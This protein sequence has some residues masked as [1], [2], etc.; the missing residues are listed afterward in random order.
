M[1]MA[2]KICAEYV[3]DENAKFEMI[4]QTY[5]KR[6]KEIK[7]LTRM[8]QVIEGQVKEKRKVSESREKRMMTPEHL[9]YP[10]RIH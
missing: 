10:S 8:S 5:C 7:E 3:N 1:K 9:G 2:R 4:Y 6:L